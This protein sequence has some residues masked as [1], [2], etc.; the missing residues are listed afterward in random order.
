MNYKQIFCQPRAHIFA[1]IKW[2]S[3]RFTISNMLN[4]SKID[5]LYHNETCCRIKSQNECYR[6][7]KVWFPGLNLNE[8]RY[9]LIIK[10]DRW[11]EISKKNSQII[12]LVPQ[13]LTCFYFYFY[14]E[15]FRRI[16]NNRTYKWPK[17]PAWFI[18]CFATL[19]RAYACNC[20]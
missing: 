20:A 12:E 13:E 9:Y 11:G 7:I 6:L 19:C 8:I 15:Y 18:W 5:M 2:Q 16:T 3:I 17:K 1:N 14:V 4:W 10:D